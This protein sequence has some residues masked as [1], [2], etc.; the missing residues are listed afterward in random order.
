MM[1]PIQRIARYNLLLEKIQGYAENGTQRSEI[2]EMVRYF[3]KII[4]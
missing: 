3:K 1:R 4:F 2:A